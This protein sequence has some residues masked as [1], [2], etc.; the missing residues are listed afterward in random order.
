MKFYKNIILPA[1]YI[2][3]FLSFSYAQPAGGSNPVRIKLIPN[4]LK[5]DA[6]S[7]FQVS[8]STTIEKNWHIN[9]NKPN[10]EN[11]IPTEISSKN[12]SVKLIKVL[13]PKPK[14]L[15]LGISEN[16]VLVFEG[17]FKIE[18]TFETDKNTSAGK[19]IIPVE[20]SYQACNDQTC[21]PPQKIIENLT[22]EI[23]SAGKN[24]E[25]LINN[26]PVK[27]TSKQIGTAKSNTDTSGNIPPL[28]IHSENQNISSSNT[29]NIFMAVLFAFLGGIILNL[30]PCV[31]PVLSLKILGFVKQAGEDK[32]KTLNHG[33]IFM[34]GVLISFWILAGLLLILR[35]GGENL[36][37]GFQ[38]QSPV[39]LIILSV[40][41]FLFSLSLFGVFEVGNSFTRLQGKSNGY[42]GSF[43]SGVTATIIA[44]PCTAPFMGSALGFALTQPAYYSMIIFSFIG[45]GMSSPY[46]LLAANPKFLKYVPKSGAWMETFKQFMGFLLV[47]T[48]LWLI[49]VFS[50]QVETDKIVILLFALLFVSLGAWVWGKWGSFINSTRIRIIAFIISMVLIIIPTYKTIESVRTDNNKNKTEWLVYSPEL[51]EKLKQ[52][53][54]PIFIDFTAKWCLTCQVNKKAVLHTEE[55]EK[56][57]K[58]YGVVTVIADWTNQDE[59]I[60]KALSQYNRNSVPLYV[61]YSRD[62]NKPPV[63][64]PELLTVGIVTNALKNL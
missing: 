59:I 57:F 40:F 25:T 63:V 9:S 22:V 49:W 17:E 48:T 60:A 31:L 3:I 14:E 46:V 26:E 52:Q 47:A 19:L 28:V 41:F 20:F 16:P 18:L 27:D 44:T 64:L 61:L 42:F 12:K 39:F 62:P 50:N 43:M 32:K 33:L 35:A 13:Y 58:E 34:L 5:V 36:G 10:D 51:I 6:G 37:W 23:I 29:G 11:L 1:V 7:R 8:I 21:M 45:L 2:I 55:V 56:A 53:K 24:K 30:M 4:S 54:V 15:K 38:L